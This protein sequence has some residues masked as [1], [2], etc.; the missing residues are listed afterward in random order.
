M[1]LHVWSADDGE[2]FVIA[3]T[4]EDALA[5]LVEAV[6]PVSVDPIAWE[7]LPDDR[8]FTM[9]EEDGSRVTKTCAEWC[10][11]VGRGYFAHVWYFCSPN[12]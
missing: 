9:R 4:E 5:V 7:Q 1:S 10:T 2:E 3:E 8:P 6:G 11:E 12:Y